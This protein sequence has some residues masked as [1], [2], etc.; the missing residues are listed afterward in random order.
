MKKALIGYVIGFIVTGYVGLSV[1]VITKQEIEQVLL[2]VDQ[3]GLKIPFSKALCRE[4]FFTF[5]GSYED[6]DALHKGV[7]ASFVVQG[8]SAVSE[9]E[10][11]LKYL[12]SKGLD[13]N[14]IDMHQLSPLHGAVL[15]NS[16]DEVEMLLRNGASINLKDQKFGL[17][18]LELALKLQGEDKLTSDR[19]A[20]IAPLRNAK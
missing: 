20:V 7:G 13:V 14:H 6:I 4:Y 18:P 3:G 19:Q 2:C 9:R 12:I 11:V 17:T 10:Q 1:Y 5:R 15:S 16:A 8:K